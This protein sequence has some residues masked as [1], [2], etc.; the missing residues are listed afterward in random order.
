MSID[1]EESDLDVYSEEVEDMDSAV[2]IV[3][4]LEVLT[5]TLGFVYTLMYFTM[6]YFSGPL[7][8]MIAAVAIGLMH[9]A[10]SILEIYAGWGLWQLKS[11]AWRTALSVNVAS[12]VLF[13][14]SISIPFIILN[15]VL[16]AYL[17]TRRGR[18]IYSDIQAT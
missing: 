7:A 11:W 3:S 18:N 6:G 13:L 10:L 17:R 9:G 15:A 8:Y 16:V 14:F 12:L 4:T 1:E 2:T 5:G